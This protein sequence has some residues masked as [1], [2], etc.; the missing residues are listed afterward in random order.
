M[1]LIDILF[2]IIGLLCVAASFFLPEKLAGSRQKEEKRAADLKEAVLAELRKK[3]NLDRIVTDALAELS[4]RMRE[5]KNELL[6]DSES[7]LDRMSNEKMLSFGE[8]SDEV[9][10]KINQNHMEVVFLYDMLKEKESS[11]KDFAARLDG[12]NQQIQSLLQEAEEENARLGDIYQQ[13][14]TLSKQAEATVSRYEEIRRKQAIQAEARRLAQ[15]QAQEL[16]QRQV[17]QRTQVREEAEPVYRSVRPNRPDDRHTEKALEE[18]AAAETL[19]L[20]RRAG[21]PVKEAP[22]VKAAPRQAV[23][24]PV[25]GQES[26]AR[27]R[28]QAEGQAAAGTAPCP[29][30]RRAVQDQPERARTGMSASV[31]SGQRE[32][33]SVKRMPIRTP[34]FLDIPSEEELDAASIEEQNDRI[35]RM[36]R[37]GMSILEISKAMGL[38]QGEVKLVVDL[39]HKS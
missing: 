16:A 39:F 33:Q 8:Y 23:R 11:L 31:V 19:M 32:S 20:Q 21:D 35:L 36:Y 18:A 13:V 17:P 12:T 34:E 9:L 26:R 14:Q 37:G 29:V 1:E 22:Q 15:I 30:V 4:G 25:Q 7:E 6:L 28:T 5:Q 3:E 24:R 38:G 10:E 2:V 27:V